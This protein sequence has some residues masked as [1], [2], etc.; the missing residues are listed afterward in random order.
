MN[1][2]NPERRIHQRH[3]VHLLIEY[4]AKDSFKSD[5]IADISG[6]GLFIQ[7]LTPLPVGTEI[8]FKIAFPSIPK[9]IEAKGVVVRVSE[10]QISDGLPGMGIKFIGLTED[11]ARFINTMTLPES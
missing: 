7:T 10:Q 6:G 9:L 1:P 2:F 3:A 8:E 5:Y 4:A 11:N